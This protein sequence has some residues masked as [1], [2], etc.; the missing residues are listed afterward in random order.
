VLL[1]DDGHDNRRLLALYLRDA[2]AE[3]TLAE[4]G[5]IGCDEALAAAATGDPFGVILM[6][7]QMPE[8]D[9]YGAA[10]LLRA[11]GYTGP[12]VALTAHAMAEDRDKCLSAGCSDYLSKPVRRDLL[13]A[14][15]AR[16]LHSTVQ[17]TDT[18]TAVDSQT[19]PSAVRAN[20]EAAP[21]TVR[22]NITDEGILVFLD[23]YVRELPAR[24][25]ELEAC[26]ARKDLDNL[27]LKTHNLRGTGGLYG[28]MPITEAAATVENLIHAHAS[29]DVIATKVEALI[30]V[31]R[32]VEGFDAK[33]PSDG[34]QH[35]NTQALADNHGDNSRR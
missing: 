21:S 22:S 17:R 34:C 7:M 8:L 35:T 23:S 13:L 19:I 14:T 6:D 11:K 16:H 9:G 25:A 27:S 18:S 28:L 4:N 5:R 15:V 31:L 20:D 3:V 33:M 26:L 30:D 2:G 10:A 24:V 32:R 12:I 1:V 29:I